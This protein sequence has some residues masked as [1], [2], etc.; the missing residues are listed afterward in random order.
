LGVWASL[1]SQI[2]NDAGMST[3]NKHVRA[4]ICASCRAVSGRRRVVA[5][6]TT[7]LTL[8]LMALVLTIANRPV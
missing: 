6:A 4:L 1:T 2:T 3:V 8:V 5:T 7:R